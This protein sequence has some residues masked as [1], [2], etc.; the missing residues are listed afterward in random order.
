MLVGHTATIG[1]LKSACITASALAAPFVASL[2]RFKALGSHLPLICEQIL[3][4]SQ[5][6]SF[7]GCRSYISNEVTADAVV[8]DQRRHENMETF[9][10]RDKEKE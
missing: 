3:P 8:G 7:K 10:E 1:E 4:L 5:F 2:L 6:F 9:M